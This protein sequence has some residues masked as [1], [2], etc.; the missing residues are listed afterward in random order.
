MHLRKMKDPKCSHIACTSF[1]LAYVSLQLL[2]RFS[3][4][5]DLVSQNTKTDRTYDVNIEEINL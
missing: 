5:Y 3:N 1:P 2:T 4:Q